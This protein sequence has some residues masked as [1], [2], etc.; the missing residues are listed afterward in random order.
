MRYEPAL[1]HGVAMEAAAELVVH[2]AFGHFAQREQHHVERFLVFGAEMVAQ[3]EL[4]N[5]RAGKLGSAAESAELAIEGAAENEEA[6]IEH[7]GVDGR[8]A[9]VCRF[10]RRL[11][12]ELLHHIA[13]R[14]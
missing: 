10:D 4:K 9:G 14:V 8:P 3:Q 5:R 11:L 6:A 13:R 1:V 2:A 7:A 12:L